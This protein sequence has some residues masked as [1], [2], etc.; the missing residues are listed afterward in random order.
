MEETEEN[1]TWCSV[2]RI[3]LVKENILSLALDPIKESSELRQAVLDHE[4]L[5]DQFFATQIQDSVLADLQAQ[6]GISDEVFARMM[7]SRT[8]YVDEKNTLC[9]LKA[10]DELLH[11]EDHQKVDALVQ[12]LDAHR[13]QI[14][15]QIDSCRV[16][17]LSR[18][19]LLQTLR[20]YQTPQFTEMFQSTVTRIHTECGSRLEMM[21]LSREKVLDGSRKKH[22]TAWWLK[23]TRRTVQ[24][25][26]KELGYLYEAI[27]KDYT[28]QPPQNLA[29]VQ[30]NLELVRTVLDTSSRQHKALL[31][32]IEQ[33]K[34]RIYP[35]MSDLLYEFRAVMLYKLDK[36][37]SEESISQF[38]LEKM[39]KDVEE[40]KEKFESGEM[41]QVNDMVMDVEYLAM[42]EYLETHPEEL[43]NHP[44]IVPISG[45]VKSSIVRLQN[46]CTTVLELWGHQLTPQ[47]KSP[48]QKS[49][50]RT[51]PNT[52][53]PSL[54]D[55][56]LSDPWA[57]D[58][59]G[60]N[61]L[62]NACLQGGSLEV[63]KAVLE[64]PGCD[65][66]VQDFQGDT[67]LHCLALRNIISAEEKQ[68]QEQVVSKIVALNGDVDRANQ[69][70]ETP[71][72]LAVSNSQEYLACLLLASKADPMVQASD[73]QTVLDRVMERPSALIASYLAKYHRNLSNDIIIQCSRD[74]LVPVR[75]TG[76][77]NGS[78]TSPHS[79]SG[80]EDLKS[81]FLLE[82]FS[83]EDEEDN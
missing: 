32:V 58:N 29:L 74:K 22:I 33:L 51:T 53:E 83:S 27:P 72:L 10:L 63:A 11:N 35:R 60:R 5:V 39:K 73:G 55:P 62:H 49:P 44:H 56:A 12:Q 36:D 20:E 79:G 67:A 48:P 70:G 13:N 18:E 19:T 28:N 17:A 77:P 2:S 26:L 1:I 65:V 41:R 82:D 61:T 15:K 57:L 78:P 45:L 8:L 3:Y 34:S 43:V 47:P 46:E 42:M 4:Q 30:R 40:N 21:R 80:N 7:R 16:F 54:K 23:E 6:F 31:D 38:T 9:L 75:L 68:L 50:G 66:N 37:V 64:L 25:F 81:D 69:N 59:H 52:S 24:T 76:E 14:L 71:L